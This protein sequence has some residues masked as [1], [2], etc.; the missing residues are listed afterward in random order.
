MGPIFVVYADK[1]KTGL[2]ASISVG[3][4][5]DGAVAAAADAQDVYHGLFKRVLCV[6]FCVRMYKFCS[7]FPSLS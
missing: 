6:R 2:K 3:G 4:G 1:N 7:R 5:G